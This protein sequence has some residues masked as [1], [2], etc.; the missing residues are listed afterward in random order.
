MTELIQA[1][2]A[3]VVQDGLQAGCFMWT[4]VQPAQ[5][6]HVALKSGPVVSSSAEA[7]MAADLSL[8]LN[9]NGVA[10][11]D[12]L[13]VTFFKE[14][15]GLLHDE[16]G[17]LKCSV[18]INL[19]GPAPV[20]YPT[21]T[22]LIVSCVSEE[23]LN[24][25]LLEGNFSHL[26]S[27]AAKA[28]S[29]VVFLAS[30]KLVRLANPPVPSN[31]KETM[32]KEG[33]K[34]AI[35]TLKRA[36][37]CVSGTEEEITTVMSSELPLCC[38][39]HPTVREE[40]E[41]GEGFPQSFCPYPCLARYD[42]CT[43]ANH[44]CVK[45]CHTGSHEKCLYGSNNR[46]PCG[47]INKAVCSDPA[48]CG[49]ATVVDLPCSHQEV[50]GWDDLRRCVR[51]K[52]VKHKLTVPCGKDAS[53]L[54]CTADTVI[55]CGVCGADR[56]VQCCD[57]EVL[58]DQECQFC[59]ALKEAI[60]KKLKA[61]EIQAREEERLKKEQASL[62]LR[63]SQVEASKK[64]IFV[65]GQR[66]AVVNAEYAQPPEGYQF[67]FGDRTWLASG[68]KPPYG[69]QGIIR[70][71]TNHPE[72][73]A[74]LVYLIESQGQEFFIMM[75][76]GLQLHNVVAELQNSQHNVL[77]ITAPEA[78]ELVPGEWRIYT[79]EIGRDGP[80][81]YEPQDFKDTA[82]IIQV[83]GTER[84][85]T[86]KSLPPAGRAFYVEKKLKHPDGSNV[87]VYLMTDVGRGT[88]S[89]TKYMLAGPSVFRKPLQKGQK[90]LVT[91]PSR[92]T[93]SR[94]FHMFFR[95][96]PS[97]QWYDGPVHAND[98]GVVSN[99]MNDGSDPRCYYY[100]VKMDVRGVYAVFHYKGIELDE[101]AE[102]MRKEDSMM[103]EK[104]DRMTQEEWD[105]EKETAKEV[106]KKQRESNARHKEEAAATLNAIRISKAKGEKK[107]TAA[108]KSQRDTE[109]NRQREESQIKRKR[110]D[111]EE[112]NR[113]ERDISSMKR[114]RIEKSKEAPVGW[115]DG[116]EDEGTTVTAP[117]AA[118]STV[119]ALPPLSSEYTPAAYNPY[120]D[121][122]TQA[123]PTTPPAQTMI[124]SAYPQ[125]YPHPY[126][127]PQQSPYY[128]HHYHHHYAA[129]TPS[130]GPQQQLPQNHPY[131][132]YKPP[133][134]K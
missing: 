30:T 76:K 51:Y 13:I 72:D 88:G 93:K 78:P 24:K 84:F 118:S 114:R 43:V 59:F 127:H 70:K 95:E 104:L 25:H 98:S 54:T 110:L 26:L 60:W 20:S 5:P 46:L 64:G 14:Q 1:G 36:A 57:R 56:V 21:F 45:S 22:H 80:G 10:Y 71:R 124:H 126:H 35:Q 52:E 69:T 53:T 12:I 79:P 8:Y 11:D 16:L 39:R 119:P 89:A 63:L 86:D 40:A 113:N 108:E 81:I 101:E 15:V 37:F 129:A 97:L 38:P 48:D 109:M 87:T 32:W 103:F 42:G 133:Q 65:E 75:G 3:H 33:W 29:T 27:A 28:H 85:Y 55:E 19:T 122:P 125:P 96:I 31:K 74:S 107:L 7:S 134:Y 23:L 106:Y 131:N 117:A 58:K 73:F 66:V 34:T 120:G 130:P 99:I 62:Q 49:N 61:A 100:I 17:K 18:D 102:R 90:V 132:Q 68:W 44:V 77:M 92:L 94:P 41:H 121:P 91:S 83:G 82:D 47:H 6:R 128:Y 4:Y 123:A 112:E 105:G 50:I 9:T 111:R 116:K 67:V 2:S 115:E